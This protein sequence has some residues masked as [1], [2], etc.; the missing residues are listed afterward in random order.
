MA[1]TTHLPVVKAALAYLGEVWPRAVPFMAL[2]ALAR[3]RLGDV[4]PADAGAERQDL[5]AL[6]K[7]F[8]TAYATAGEALVALS[9][10][11]P[12]L[13]DRVSARL[14]A[15]PLARLEAAAGALQV[16]N[17]RH[18][19]AAVTPFDRH[20]L[21]FLDGTRD[22]P[23]LVE[24][25]LGRVQRELMQISQEDQPV[26]DPARARAILAEVLEQQLP[27]LAQAALLLA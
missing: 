22:R 11:P 14:V 18:E 6:G 1:L 20:L 7:A 17:L 8:L 3:Q 2:P 26:T 4:P 9:L 15:S 5:V 12:V 21:P 13:A 19:V 25:L 10:T 23:A 27:K 16:T 24:S